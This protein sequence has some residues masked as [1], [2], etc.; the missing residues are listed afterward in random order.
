MKSAAEKNGAWS[1]NNSGC[2]ADGDD[3][4]VTVFR[5]R[6]PNVGIFEPRRKGRLKVQRSRQIA[7]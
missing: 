7:S 2:D 6:D 1:K 3:P 4:V 5:F